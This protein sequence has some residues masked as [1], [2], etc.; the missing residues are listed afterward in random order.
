MKLKG[1]TVLITRPAHLSDALADALRAQGAC[2]I[3]FPTIAIEDIADQAGLESVLAAS[4]APDIG[5]FVSTGAVVATARWLQR[6]QLRW[7]VKMQC[8]AV[9]LKTAQS[10]R[11]A[12]ALENV[13]T[14][15]LG[16]GA[17]A[18]LEA[19]PLR[20]LDDRS[21]A[22]FDGAGGSGFVQNALEGKCRILSICPVYRIVQPNSDISSVRKHLEGNGIDYVVI[23]SVA[24]ARNLFAMLGPHL[25][26][27]LSDS[28]FVVYSFR[29]AQYLHGLG[30]ARVAVARQASDEATVAAIS[31]RDRRQP[32]C[33]TQP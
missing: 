6:N 29:I 12:F 23:T 24:G 26:G 16:S 25:S 22:V 9:G 21:V 19:G 18:L 14:P 32:E 5:I 10:A 2:V 20:N 3:R 31:G 13:I 28:L 17:K 7:P 8:A 11:E 27:C 1:E 15:E 4:S 33:S 30:Y